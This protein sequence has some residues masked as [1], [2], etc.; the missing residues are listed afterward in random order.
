VTFAAELAAFQRKADENMDLLVRNV[1]IEAANS[2]IEMSPVDT[3]RFR[4]N[5]QHGTNNANLVTT[6]EVDGT[7]AATKARIAASCANVVAGGD[8]FV[9]NNLPYAIPLEYGHSQ[10]APAGMV[11]VTV[12]RLQQLVNTALRSLKQ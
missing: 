11:R 9:T 7:G 4:G 1:T 5:W 12:A 8:E 2:V 6:Q 10:Q 3:G